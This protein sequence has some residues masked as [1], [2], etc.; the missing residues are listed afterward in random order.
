MRFLYS[1]FERKVVRVDGVYASICLS[2]CHTVVAE[3]CGLYVC[4]A[5]AHVSD[6][7]IDLGSIHRSEPFIPVCL[8]ACRN[9]CGVTIAPSKV[10]GTYDSIFPAVSLVNEG[11][12]EVVPVVE[13]FDIS[14]FKLAAPLVLL[15]NCVVT[16]FPAGTVNRSDIAPK[17]PVELSS[18]PTTVSNSR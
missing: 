8:G 16:V 10:V 7:E 12:Y 14:K 2:I 6:R 3:D 5:V 13:S 4:C 1:Q 9:T 17:N 15:T 11:Y 18:L